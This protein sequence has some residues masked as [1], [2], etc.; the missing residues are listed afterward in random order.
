MLDHVGDA[1]ILLREDYGHGEFLEGTKKIATY[2]PD[3]QSFLAEE[4][5]PLSGSL[6]QN[7]REK[8]NRH[9]VSL[10]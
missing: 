8:F 6:P 7:A 2:T 10:T 9:R 5:L 4:P 1:T 3:L